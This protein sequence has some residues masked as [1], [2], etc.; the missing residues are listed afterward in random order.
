MES[1]ELLT[2]CLKHTPALQQH[3]RQLNQDRSQTFKSISSIQLKDAMWIYTEPHSMRLKLA[4]TIHAQVGET[5]KT[6]VVQQRIPVEY[7]IQFQMC[8]D[9]NREYTNRTWHAVVQLRQRGGSSKG[10]VL[11]EMYIAKHAVLKNDILSVQTTR[12]GYDFYFLQLLSAQALVSHISKVYPM[13]IKT[14]SKMV[15]EDVK[16]N[17]KHMKYTLL[18]DLVPLGKDDLVMWDMNEGQG[19]SRPSTHGAIKFYLVLKMAGSIHL[20]HVCPSTGNGNLSSMDHAMIVLSP[21]RYWKMEKQ[22]HVVGS[23]KRLIRFVVLDVELLDENNY[24]KEG[25]SFDE[26]HDR[27][28][29][30]G[31]SSGIDKYR[32]AQVQVAREDDMGKNDEI[33]SCITHLGNLLQAGDVAL[34]YDVINSVMTGS[35]EWLMDDGFESQKSIIPDVVLVKKVTGN[36]AMA[37]Q[38]NNHGSRGTGRIK[39]KKIHSKPKKGSKS[40]RHNPRDKASD[41]ENEDAVLDEDDYQESFDFEEERL[42]LEDELKNDP[43]LAEA[44]IEAETILPL[45]ESNRNEN[46]FE[47]SNLVHESY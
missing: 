19:R 14:S 10:L 24:A 18:C 17:T 8:Q 23:S 13:K 30:T 12:Q 4:L 45:N 33:M 26:G 7:K 42:Q 29:Y 20:A 1:S 44:L 34:G 6:V 47:E 3:S 37:E 43:D 27:K 5:A 40:R 9:C 39:N 28:L 25:N 46:E 35:E 21:E 31:P 38:N 11:L 16:N 22:M 41:I 15:S 2:L 36:S 32:F